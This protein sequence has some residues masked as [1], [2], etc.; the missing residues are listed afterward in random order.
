MATFADK[1]LQFNKSLQLTVALPDGIR[2][3]NPFERNGRALKIA[4]A[5]YKK[6]YNDGR[7]RKFIIGINPGRFGAGVTGVPFTDTKRL[8]E[9]CGI[10]FPGITTHEPSSVFIY[11]MIDAYGGAAAFYADFYINSVCPLGF[12]KINTKGKEV[13]YN[14]YD[15]P[16]LSKI[17]EPFML[18]CLRRQIGFGNDTATCYC[19]GTGKNF[20]FL[21]LLNKK[22]RLFDD[23]IPLEHPRYI[24]QYKSA[25]KAY[26]I[27]KYLTLLK[28][29]GITS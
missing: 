4:T 5:F 13:N 11:E 16:A 22:H 28:G 24:M 12:T 1:I 9:K 19:L 15:H 21:Q 27:D 7:K 3:M 2:V 29:A 26:Y 14:Y 25:Q 8:Q 23:I 17:V 20:R 18:D 6:Y 10:A